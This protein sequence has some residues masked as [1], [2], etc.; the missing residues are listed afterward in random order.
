[1]ESLIS[2]AHQEE[3]S[4]LPAKL[5]PRIVN[6]NEEEEATC[7]VSLAYLEQSWFKCYLLL[8]LCSILTVFY[9]PVRLYWSVEARAVWMYSPVVTLQNTTHLLVKGKDGN[10]EIV[11]LK[12][13]SE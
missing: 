10:I 13:L 4:T 8:P 3:D 1:M 9:L 2:S 5:N 11:E 7:I 6:F 12:N